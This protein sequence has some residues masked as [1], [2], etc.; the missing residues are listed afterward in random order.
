LSQVEF[1]VYLSFGEVKTVFTVLGEAEQKNPA[2]LLIT[3]P[4]T[5]FS[6]L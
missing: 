5:F 1:P 4:L 3:G 2:S 6:F